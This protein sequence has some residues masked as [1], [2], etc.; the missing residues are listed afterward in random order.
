M[1][2]P[3]RLQR[4]VRTLRAHADDLRRRGVEHAS[5]FGSVARGEDTNESDV[6]ILIALDPAARLDAFGY[7]GILI[8]LEEWIRRPVQVARRDKLKPHVRRHALKDEVRAF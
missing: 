4:V 2:R 3:P 8:D 7:A 6:D 1:K 5:V